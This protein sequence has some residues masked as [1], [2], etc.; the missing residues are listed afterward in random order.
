MIVF[1]ALNAEVTKDYL[2]LRPSLTHVRSNEPYKSIE[3]KAQP[4]R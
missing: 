4:A 1:P 2:I 3:T